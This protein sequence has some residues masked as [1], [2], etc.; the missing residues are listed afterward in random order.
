MGVLH[1]WFKKIIGIS[2]KLILIW[3]STVSGGKKLEGVLFTYKNLVLIRFFCYHC[4]EH[5]QLH[6]YLSIEKRR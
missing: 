3:P 4:V 1:K 5:D 2:L 6:Q